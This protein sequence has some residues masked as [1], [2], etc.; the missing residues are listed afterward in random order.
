MILDTLVDRAQAIRDTITQPN[1]KQRIEL[2]AEVIVAECGEQMHVELLN[3]SLL[4]CTELCYMKDETGRYTNIDA[5]TYRILIV[6]PWSSGGW[7]RWTLRQW[8][9]RVMRSILITR[10]A[11]RRVAPL[12]DYAASRK[13][14]YLNL[15][16]YP[17][18]DNALTYWRRNPITLADWHRYADI[19][20]ERERGRKGGL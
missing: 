2:A 1:I 11:M 6:K 7:E 20:R 12:F 17:S 16:I 8:E 9:S 10:S 14:W 15:G 4:K 18:F 13:Q 19:L 5:R 3:E